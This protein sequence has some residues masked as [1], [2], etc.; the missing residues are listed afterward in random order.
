MIEANTPEI[1]VDEL[2]HKIRDEVARRHNVSLSADSRAI[3]INVTTMAN[4]SYIEA[5]LNNAE[6]KSQ[7]RTEIPKKFDRFPFNISKP[8]QKFALKLYAFLF[9]EQR[10]INFSL[11]QAL[12]ES[13]ALNRRLIEQVTVLQ[14]QMKDVS[15]RL[16]A[17]DE[18]LTTTL[19]ATDERLTATD[20]RLTA[21]DERLTATDEHQATALRVTEERLTTTLSTLQERYIR[22]DS[23]LKNDL[24]QQKRL[25]TLFLEEAQQRLPEPFNP[26]QLQTFVN[27]DQHLLDAFYVAFEEQF[28]G[29]REDI[30]N[31]LKVYLPWLEEAEIGTPELPILDVGCGRGEWLE[32]LRE[33]G[34]TARGLDL[35]RVMLD[36]CRARGLEVIEGDVIAYLQSLPDGSLGAVTGFHIIEH[37]PFT[38]LIRLL[39]ETIRVLH[40]GGL[41]I[42]E[43]PNPEN[44]LVGACNF[45]SD[46]THRNPLFP[47][48]VKF[49]VEQRGFLDVQLLRLKEYRIKDPLQFIEANHPLAPQ[50]NS[51]IEIAKSS[52]YASPD[53]AV[54][55]KKA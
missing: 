48:S 39:D 11:V 36:E 9:K 42:F 45:Y 25:L 21:T 31:R 33:T 17:T 54:I 29:S 53:F 13:V 37:L 18:R 55:G 4:L 52:F 30:F 16:T 15:D 3:D 7:V 50:L 26:E 34:Y 44:I 1:N 28:R 19:T 40:P 2:M 49:L 22:N 12:R 14:S 23:Y 47:P 8:L 20:E 6:A 32:L 51:L 10:A 35:N 27:E 46:P 24:V 43:T 38:L 41:A 5:L